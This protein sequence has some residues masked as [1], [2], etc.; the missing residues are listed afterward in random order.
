MDASQLY[1][2]GSL[3]IFPLLV[4]GLLQAAAAEERR[5]PRRVRARLQPRPRR[6]GA[7][8]KIGSLTFSRGRFF[9]N[10]A[11][12]QQVSVLQCL[13]DIMITSGHGQKIVTGR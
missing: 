9:K 5:D 2:N 8:G 13:S 3:V 7:A 6:Q 12:N 10:V 11:V 4:P 1:N